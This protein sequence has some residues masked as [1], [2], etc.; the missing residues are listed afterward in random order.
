MSLTAAG[1]TLNIGYDQ[2]IASLSGVAGSVVNQEAGTLTVGGD[3]SSTTFAGV[4]NVL[5]PAGGLTKVGGGTFT[6]T[7]SANTYG[8]VTTIA[9]GAVQIGD[10]SASPGS[11]AGNVVNN[12]SA[13]G[14][15][16]FNTPAGMSL[17]YSGNISGSGTGAVT[18]TGP[19]TVLLSGGNTQAGGLTVNGGVL[20]VNA[21]QAYG[22]A[23]IISAG[24][25]QI[26]SAPA[27]LPNFSGLAYRLDASNS[28]NLSNSGSAVTN[29]GSVTQWNDIGGNG[30]NFTAGATAPTYLAGRIN[31]LGVVNFP[32]NGSSLVA[33]AT[34]TAQTVFVVNQ[35]NSY[36][37]LGGLWGQVDNPGPYATGI[38]EDLLSS[39]NPDAWRI[40][41][42]AGS[43]FAAAYYVNGVL[44]TSG[45]SNTSAPF[46]IGQPQVVEAVCASPQNWAT[47]LG[48]YQSSAAYNGYI[49]EVLVY[50]GVLTTGQQAA[51]NEYLEAKWLGTAS[52]Y[53]VGNN[54]LPSSTPV[55]L[56]GAGA[57][58]NIGYDQTIASLSGVAG[59]TVNQEAGTLSVGGDNSNT[60]F[61]GG[62]NGGGS[63]VK[64]GGGTLTLAG[65]NNYGGMTTV[66]GGILQFA[67]PASLYNATVGS[68]TAANISVASGAALAVNVGGP[69]DFQPA[70]VTNLLA[71]IDGAVNNNGLQAGSSLGFDTTNA[72]AAVTLTSGIA[73]TTGPGG[74]SVGL[75]KLGPGTLILA[76]NNAY[77]G[78][79]AINGGT[80]EFSNAANQTLSG[81]I[82][83]GGALVTT[84]PG[85]LTLLGN[86]TYS[87]PTTVAGGTLQIGNGTSGE[88]L[89]SPSIAMSN[90]ATVVFNHADPLPYSGTISG[91]GQLVKTGS[92]LLTLN[93][94]STY[95]GATTIS[96]GTLDLGDNNRLPTATALTIASGGAF[97]LAGNVQTVGSLSGPAGAI[98]TN[99]LP[100]YPSTLTVAMS[101]GSTT[102]AGNIIG[103]DALALSGS[104]QLTLS[105]T[106]A[107]TG[108]TTVSGG[109]LDIA[110]PRRWPAAGW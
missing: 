91:S 92:G 100:L 6:L 18:K 108:G 77:S 105:G 46:T 107:Y 82:G 49:G 50:S 62:L 13:A 110:A 3:N 67:A 27:S 103:N 98:V 84:G 41:S 33:S 99:S 51:V 57:T 32:G 85:M 26:N 56:T 53:V 74:G 52:G 22:G 64:Q 30:N 7:N 83:G 80:L 88:A 104:G 63:L 5:S 87:G 15:L 90:N 69:S 47:A 61:A 44:Q 79:T 42:L 17:A 21:A 39:A 43:D 28:A 1:A 68:W 95:S 10:G 25:L 58:L 76:G 106:N 14:A 9:A 4:L 20:A 102:F 36:S 54:L 89:A 55:S 71:G 23:T 66:N 94:A 75:V 38:R 19:G 12:S 8:A 2:T 16:I 59:S 24:T 70:D 65:A 35:V 11:L 96:A 93:G 101:A 81:A 86:N 60:T 34:A 109:T 72:T 45:G 48:Q 31:G 40:S 29:G 78:P 37:E 97:D 73:D